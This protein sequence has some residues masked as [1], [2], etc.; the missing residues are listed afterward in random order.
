M[1]RSYIIIKLFAVMLVCVLAAFSQGSDN[2]KH[3][4]SGG[5]SFDYP[6]GWTLEDH[7]NADAQQFTLMRSGSNVQISI[8]VH[9]GRVDTPERIAQ[10]KSKI[11]D[12]IIE[13]LSNNFVQM[14]AQ[15]KRSPA[16]AIQIGGAQAEG[17]HV[18]AV[19]DNIPGEAAVYW[20]ALNKRFIVLTIFGPDQ[21]IKQ[22]APAWDAVRNS[23][24]VEENRPAQRPAASPSPSP[25]ASPSPSSSPRPSHR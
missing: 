17:T 15:P 11:A 10:A 2:L 25:S 5:L 18:R 3:Y 22:A 12:P 9:K 6:Q 4:N 1:R 13:N 23:I 20:L 21:E 7:S 24:H 8:F 14:G 19:L 16:E